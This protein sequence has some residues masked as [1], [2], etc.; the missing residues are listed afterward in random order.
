MS[1]KRQLFAPVNPFPFGK[2]TEEATDI[3]DDLP[4]ILS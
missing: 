1:M 3:V 2:D 4:C